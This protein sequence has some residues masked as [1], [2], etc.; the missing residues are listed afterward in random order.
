MYRFVSRVSPYRGGLARRPTRRLTRLPVSWYHRR[1]RLGVPHRPTTSEK[2]N[3]AVAAAVDVLEV[4]ELEV[5]GALVG[6]ASAAAMALTG[7]DRLL[8]SIT[9]AARPRYQVI[10]QFAKAERRVSTEYSMSAR[11]LRACLDVIPPDLSE[12]NL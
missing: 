5:A 11:Y 1:G 10:R 6:Q 4:A 3:E 9:N 7:S 8:K 2:V 12:A